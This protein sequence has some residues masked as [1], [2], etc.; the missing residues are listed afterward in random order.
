MPRQRPP[1]ST[2]GATV[3]VRDLTA[4]DSPLANQLWANLMDAMEQTLDDHTTPT[5]APA[6]RPWCG[7]MG[8]TRMQDTAPTTR[9]PACGRSIRA[10]IEPTTRTLNI[11]RHKRP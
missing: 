11:P 2:T 10:W 7:L 6:P 8:A 4:P 9:C 5:Q 3:H 1:R